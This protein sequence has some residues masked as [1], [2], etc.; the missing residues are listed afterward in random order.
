MNLHVLF[1]I[2]GLFNERFFI[3]T[4][5][6]TQQPT[7]KTRSPFYSI[8]FDLLL[9]KYRAAQ[10]EPQPSAETCIERPHYPILDEEKLIMKRTSEVLSLMLFPPEGTLP[11]RTLDTTNIECFD[12]F[13][14]TR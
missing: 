6:Q 11:V 8:N 14:W 10:N 2:Y 4:H 9:V 13:D 3:I 5:E 1:E 7:R 12:P